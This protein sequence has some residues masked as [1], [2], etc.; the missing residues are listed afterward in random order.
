MEITKKELRSLMRKRAA[1]ISG[2]ESSEWSGT[3]WNKVERLPQFR[4][5][6]CVLLYMSIPGEVETGKFIERWCGV[7]KIAIPLVCG[8]RLELRKYDINHLQRGYKDILEPSQDA[9]IISPSEID[10][11]IVPGMAF[12]RCN[13]KVSR[14]GRGGGFYDRLLPELE[15]PVIGV[16][17]SF[18]I[19]DNVPL[20]PWDVPLSDVITE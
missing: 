19:T 14:L 11:A 16:A 6:G 1:E 13:G 9:E 17:F 3:I 12:S 5:A 4:D 8:E 7:K 15:C 18:R 2:E 10:L 20:E